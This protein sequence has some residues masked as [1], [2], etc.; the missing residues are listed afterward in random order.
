MLPCTNVQVGGDPN[1][2]DGNGSTPLYFAAQEGHLDV[3]NWLLQQGADPIHPVRIRA[4]SNAD[5]VLCG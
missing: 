4:L 2:V 3:L 5:G 1:E